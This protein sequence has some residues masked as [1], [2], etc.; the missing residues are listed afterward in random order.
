MLKVAIESESGI[1]TERNKLYNSFNG[2]LD[3][4]AISLNMVQVVGNTYNKYGCTDVH[5]AGIDFLKQL[6]KKNPLIA[7]KILY[8]YITY[9]RTDIE[10]FTGAGTPVYDYSDEYKALVDKLATLI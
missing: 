10:T 8:D 4:A 9:R 7:G 2:T 1:N 3:L 5:Q 6:E